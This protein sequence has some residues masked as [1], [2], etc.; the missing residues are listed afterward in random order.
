VSG[1]FLEGEYRELTKRGLTEETCRKFGYR[2]ATNHAGKPVQVAD[3][4]DSDGTLVAQKVRGADK[5]FNVIGDGKNMPLFGQNLWPSTGKRVVVT[6]GEIDA[7]S[8][9][10]VFNLSWPSVSLANGAQSAKKA[11]QRALE[12]LEGYEQIVLC[13]DMDEPGRAAVAE[14]A[15][16][17]T[18]GKCLIAELPLKD[19]N[20]MVQAGRADDLRKAIWNARGYRPD[21]IVDLD[22]IEGRVLA[23]VEMGRPWFLPTLSKATFGRRKGELIGLGAGTGVG[24]TDLL[25]QSIAYDVATLGITTGC[26]FL[27]QNVAET[28]RRIAGKLVGKRL[29]VPDGSWTQEELQDAW[30]KL[31]ASGKLHL[32]DSWGVN[33][34]P[35]IQSKIKFM[36]VSLGCEHIY[37]DHMTALAA[38][39]DDERKALEKIMAEA[40]GLAQA[41][42]IVLHYVSHLATPDGKPHEE[43][44]RVMIRHFKGSRA[45]G[46]WSH[47]MLGLERNQQADDPEERSRTTLRVLKDRFTGQSTG[48]T[49]G[50]SY[51]PQTGLLSE[52]EAFTD[53]TTEDG[54]ERESWAALSHP[55]VTWKSSS[56][57]C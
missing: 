9:A 47:F 22:D 34:W 6:E 19:A 18:P 43:G 50:L 21:G 15:S 3:Y 13:F 20:E 31:K 53:E 11:L 46:F 25:T 8:V 32:Y 39:E 57:R 26:L 38:A 29:H 17:F 35:T 23:A 16:L 12:W 4:R 42:R 40:A 14:C 27:E 41:H 10:Q 44:G 54:G 45:L 48:L 37:L 28:G 55:G 5:T 24:K 49:L 2:V 52:A 30:G 1:D 7:M 56:S 51:D 36:A 33:D